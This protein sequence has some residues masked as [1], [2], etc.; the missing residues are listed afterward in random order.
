[1]QLAGLPKFDPAARY[2][3]RRP[4]VFNGHHYNRG[5]FFECA[6]QHERLA[7]ILYHRKKIMQVQVEP[8]EEVVEEP[9]QPEEPAESQTEYRLEPRGKGWFDVLDT[10]GNAMNER[11]L[12]LDVARALAMGESNAD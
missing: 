1:M 7:R 8:S 10:D 6:A 3:V 12:R 9:E 2:Q 5:D 4:F 11:A